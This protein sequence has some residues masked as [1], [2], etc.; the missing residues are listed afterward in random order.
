MNYVGSADNNLISEEEKEIKE[1]ETRSENSKK[2]LH[3]NANIE[4]STKK[5]KTFDFSD[6]HN[7]KTENVF[8]ELKNTTLKNSEKTEKGSENN[9]LAS[10][11]G[12][13]KIQSFFSQKLDLQESQRSNSVKEKEKLSQMYYVE[14]EK[15]FQKFE[16]IKN[17]SSCDEIKQEKLK[18]IYNQVLASLEINNS[19]E[20][21]KWV[22]IGLKEIHTW[23]QKDTITE[24]KA[25]N[26]QPMFKKFLHGLSGFHT[27]NTPNEEFVYLRDRLFQPENA[28]NHSSYKEELIHVYK[29]IYNSKK[30][31]NIQKYLNRLPLFLQA[32]PSLSVLKNALK[33][34]EK[35]LPPLTFSKLVAEEDNIN[36]LS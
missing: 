2:R 23:T 10:N 8:R 31:V 33:S 30:E 18:S 13:K 21:A 6:H 32:F 19:N 28:T 27:T 17:R 12:Q 16:T 7:E 1:P 25:K 9:S 3:L 36:N 35:Q 34:L 29:I 26:Y 15:F 5:Q 11:G 4:I 22:K 20:V 24:Q 14:L